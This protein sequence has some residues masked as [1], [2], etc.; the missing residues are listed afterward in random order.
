MEDVDE[1]EEQKELSL[2]IKLCVYI[3]GLL[4]GCKK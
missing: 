3:S 1:E 2:F 4:K